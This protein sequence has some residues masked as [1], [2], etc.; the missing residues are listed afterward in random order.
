MKKQLL[1]LIAAVWCVSVSANIASAQDTNAND[2]RTGDKALMT[3]MHKSSHHKVTIVF[4]QNI[5][6]LAK[7]L[8]EM[9]KDGKNFD[10]DIARIVILEIEHGIEKIDE[11]HK[12]HLATLSEEMRKKMESEMEKNIEKEILLNENYCEL[13][14][15]L[16]ADLLD[17]EAF[18]NR[19]DAI[20]SYFQKN[21]K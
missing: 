4:R 3:E 2:D 17:L 19:A 16:Q 7:A 5:V 6:N 13:E 21:E 12:R 8:S 14:M 20:A 1:I 11:I 10:K 15:L 9:A 18:A